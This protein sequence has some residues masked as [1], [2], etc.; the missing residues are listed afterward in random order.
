MLSC[1]CPCHENTCMHEARP[2]I[3]FTNAAYLVCPLCWVEA[4]T[5]AHG[6]DQRYGYDCEVYLRDLGKDPKVPASKQC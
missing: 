4:Y 2:W 3:G 1:P 6:G 5:R